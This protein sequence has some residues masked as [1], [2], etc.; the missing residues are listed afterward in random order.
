MTKPGSSDFVL[1]LKSDTLTLCRLWRI[2]PAGSSTLYYTDH[3]RDVVFDGHTYV[4]DKSFEA[5]A[6]ENNQGTGKTN[7]E[8]TILLTETIT[9]ADIEKGRYGGAAV[10]VD[11]VFYDHLDLG[12]MPLASGLVIDAQVPYKSQAILSCSG[13]A[14]LAQH[15][16]TEQ[17]SSTCR[18]EFCDVRC[19]LDEADF[20]TDFTIDVVDGVMVFQSED[21]DPTLS[22]YNLGYVEWASGAN[23]GTKQD[24]QTS[25]GASIR[26][27]IKPPFAMQVGDTGR[28]VKGCNKT[29]DTC[30]VFNNA[31]NFRGEPYA[32]GS[33]Y[34]AAPL[35]SIPTGAAAI[36][37]EPLPDG[38]YFD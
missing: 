24:V 9:K 8:I 25:S 20:D 16:L 2:T 7:F 26:L 28:A 29:I 14:T 38:V 6:I 3:D 32:P 21:I 13:L 34:V 10:E 4:S 19:T 17:Y 11:A 27:L 36:V 1:R 33:D 31:I 22:V 12:S 35:K 37:P 15:Y 23:A 30:R 5:S 18:A